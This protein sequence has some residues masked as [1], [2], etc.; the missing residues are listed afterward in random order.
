VTDYVSLPEDGPAQVGSV[1]L[2][3]GQRIY[4]MPVPLFIRQEAGIADNS[5]QA[6]A[7]V[8]SRPMADAGD[9]WLALC[10]AH[11][12]TGL[13]PVLLSGVGQVSQGSITGETLGFFGAQDVS[14]L[15]SVSAQAVLAEG[16]YMGEAYLDPDLAAERA[17]FGAQFPGLSPAEQTRLPEAALLE[18]VIAEG[19][20]FLGLVAAG[21]P[22]DVP[23]VV[24]WSVF[25]SDSPF[26]P[27]ARCL[28]IA[29]VLR[30]WEARFGARPLRIGSDSILRVLV[31]RPPGTL[32]AATRVAAEHFAFAD[33]CADGSAST[34]R[35]LAELLVGEPVW[36]FWWD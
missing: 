6:V 17:P 29:A 12:R 25:G 36:Q 22:A 28:E 11:P 4:G 7:W 31:G 15:D 2:P 18:A 10:R 23:A 8:T 34:V 27:Q 30:S 19:P 5:Q 3:V 9:A 32:E 20:A 26:S 13:V 14:L 16:W 21:R 33:Q 35:D 24:G 1:P